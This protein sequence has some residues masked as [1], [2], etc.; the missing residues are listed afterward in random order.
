MGGPG[1]RPLSRR[2]R[3]AFIIYIAVCLIRVCSFVFLYESDFNTKFRKHRFKMKQ[4]GRAFP[5]H[6]PEKRPREG[7]STARPFIA[8]INFAIAGS[9]KP[10]P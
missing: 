3:E 9:S 7:K 6:T 4:K 8:A 2:S 5:E 1:P 10:T